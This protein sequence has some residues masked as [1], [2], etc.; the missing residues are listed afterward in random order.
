LEKVD[1]K[2]LSVNPEK[3]I[4]CNLCEYACSLEKAR[5]FNP[6]KS[7]IRVVRM[8]PF[9]NT[10]LVCKLCD[11]PPCIKVCPR[12]ALKQLE[13][14]RIIEIDEEKCNGCSW[15]IEACP[16]GA[17]RYDLDL[18]SVVIC[19]L[20]GGEPECIEICP[21]EAVEFT[22]SEE[23]IEASWIAAYNKWVNESKKMIRLAE[24]GE[25]NVFKDSV[26]TIAKIDEKLQI[27]FE[28]HKAS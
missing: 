3:C 25:L 4:G 2:F 27:L 21:T 5:E 17:I 12:D 18:G 23:A 7:R 1:Y 16:Y 14:T 15:C 20:C 11:D 9:I 19:D 8:H 26:S 6:L 22:S 24:Q 13:V 10:A 28:K